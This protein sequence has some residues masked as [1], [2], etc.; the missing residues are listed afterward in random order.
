MQGGD[1]GLW[2][3]AAY[4]ADH[5]VSTN[6]SHASFALY[7]FGEKAGERIE[8]SD[9]NANVLNRLYQIRQDKTYMTEHVYGRTALLD[10]LRESVR[11][12]G[13]PR[14]GDTLLLISDGEDNSSR[15]REDTL[16]DTLIANGVRLFFCIIRSGWENHPHT[17]E[18]K[19]GPEDIQKLALA[20]GGFSVEPF[21]DLNPLGI[22]SFFS[23]HPSASAVTA[24]SLLDAQ[25]GGYDTV[26]V[27]LPAL[28]TKPEEWQLSLTK[29]K[30]R[31]IKG[32]Q[33][34]YPHKLLPC[35]EYVSA[36]QTLSGSQ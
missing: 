17:P 30:Q 20:T 18:E 8:F 5:I 28:V 25:I 13:T 36:R 2:R 15:S 1:H 31:E 6:L 19:A 7:I 32:A 21:R 14:S 29:D 26:E 12:L 35:S 24:F 33:I 4:E 23:D 34:L 22:S 27:M 9:G 16:P 3:V 11:M 10:T